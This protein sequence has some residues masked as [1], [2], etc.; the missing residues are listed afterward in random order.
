MVTVTKKLRLRLQSTSRSFLRVVLGQNHPTLQWSW[1]KLPVVAVVVVVALELLREQHQA[2][3]GAGE[4]LQ[5]QGSSSRHL[6]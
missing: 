1:L 4:V 6:T 2:A 3:V 5:L